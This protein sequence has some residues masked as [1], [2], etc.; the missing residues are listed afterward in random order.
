MAEIP[1]FELWLEFEQWDPRPDDD[2]PADDFFNMKVKLP[3]GRRYALNVWTFEFI[4]KAR[5]P[6]PYEE[7]VGKPEEYLFVERL[8]RPLLE[9]VVARMLEAEWLCPPEEGPASLGVS[10]SP[11]RAH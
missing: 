11:L 6:W 8:D 3:D 7:G 1:A 2:D 10:S 4:H 5:F 9:R